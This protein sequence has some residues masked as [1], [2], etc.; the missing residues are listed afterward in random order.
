MVFV[1]NTE[2]SERDRKKMVMCTFAVENMTK[3]K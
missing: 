1:N 2:K 3:L